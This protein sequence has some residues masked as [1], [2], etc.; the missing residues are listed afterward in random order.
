MPIFA[1]ADMIK[2]DMIK[3][4]ALEKL[5]QRPREEYQEEVPRKTGG[6]NVVTRKRALVPC[7][8]GGGAR[9]RWSTG[10]CWTTGSWPA[11]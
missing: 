6:T 11:I 5:S 8:D 1:F 10:Q 2:P 4:L 7:H 3:P 9:R